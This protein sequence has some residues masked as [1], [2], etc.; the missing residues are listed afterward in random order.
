[1]LSLDIKGDNFYKS[2]TL[3]MNV[4]FL[5]NKAAIKEQCIHITVFKSKIL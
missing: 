3:S 1:M 5:V 4:M 2:R